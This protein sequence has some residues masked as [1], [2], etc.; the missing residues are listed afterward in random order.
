[1]ARPTLT[2]ERSHLDPQRGRVGRQKMT[3]L[4]VGAEHKAQKRQR[5]QAAVK[6]QA[7][8]RRR[9]AQVSCPFPRLT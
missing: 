2:G 6:L 7:A 9:Q 4:R 8:E 5:Q 1:M 3:Q